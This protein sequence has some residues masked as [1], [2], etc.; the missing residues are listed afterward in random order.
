MGVRLLAWIASV[1]VLL[2]ASV[3]SGARGQGEALVEEFRARCEEHAPAP[4]DCGMTA[5]A[6]MRA[7]RAA[8]QGAKAIA[9]GRRFLAWDTREQRASPQAPAAARE[10]GAAYETLALFDQA[11]EVYELAAGLRPGDADA[12]HALSDAVRVRL[13][14]GQ[15]DLADKDARAFVKTYGQSRTAQA[16]QIA[17]ALAEHQAADE[18]WAGV[19]RALAQSMA[20]IDKGPLDLQ[21]RAHALLAHANTQLGGSREVA[22]AE[23][24]RVR[25]MWNDPSAVERAIRESGDD[26]TLPRMGQALTAVGEAFF[27][28]A[29]EERVVAEAVSFPRPRTKVEIARYAE[30]R[31][32]AIERAVVAY[33]AVARLRPE[34]PPSWTVAAAARVASMWS[35]LVDDLRSSPFVRGRALDPIVEPIKVRYAK[36]ANLRCLEVAAAYRLLGDGPTACAAWLASSYKAEHYRVDE[37]VPSVREFASAPASPLLDSSM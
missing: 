19:R 8:H 10:I 22:R 33:G 13:A 35:A 2:S 7:F 21:V 11:A 23:Y 3:A 12:A 16:A 5:L 17:L 20:T 25:A 29:E 15:A 1:G 24:A 28:A 32:A 18:A 36:P 4:D 9:F 27:V 14:L 37:L 6:A 31:R 34:P 30:A 26:D